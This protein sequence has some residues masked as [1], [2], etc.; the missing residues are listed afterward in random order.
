[1]TAVLSRDEIR[2][3]NGERI[4]R[5]SSVSA[6][7]IIEPEIDLPGEVAPGQILPDRLLSTNGSGIELTPEQKAQLSREEVASMFELGL[8]IEAILMAGFCMAV[9]TDDVTDPR[10]VYR[11]HEV[12]EET[13]HSRAFSRVIAS[14]GP[15]VKH[16][17]DRVPR[18]VVGLVTS[19]GAAVLLRF[20]LLFNMLVLTGEEIP[21]WFQARAIEAD[22][23]DPFVKSVNRYHRQEEARHI[24]FAR[25][26]IPELYKQTHFLDRLAVRLLLPFIAYFLGHAFVHPLVYR[27]VGLPPLR[28]WNRVR[29]ST[30][31]V[32]GQ[33]ESIRPVL[34]ALIDNGVIKAGRV[35]RAW[36]RV[37]GVNR[38]G[39]ALAPVYDWHTQPVAA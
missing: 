26:M 16:P 20:P 17:I 21:D 14:I 39:E 1:M 29:R 13:R 27:A 19:L 3:S 2:R 36:R 10:S 9:V 33:R 32:Q 37:C 38:R 18:F 4:Q 30:P 7:R 5:L 31:R 15:T 22:G 24:S 35:P 12:G 6:K 28:T 8:R 23:V 34:Q 11:L 25:V